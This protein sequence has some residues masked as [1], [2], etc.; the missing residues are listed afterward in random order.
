MVPAKT[1]LPAVFSLGIGSPVMAASSTNDCPLTTWPSTGMRLPGRI[2]TISPG[3]IVGVGH[4]DDLAVSQHAGGLRQE[5]QHVLD[6]ALSATNGQSFEDFRCQHERCNHLLCGAAG[7]SDADVG[8]D[9]DVGRARIDGG[10]VVG[11]EDV[12]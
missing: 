12:V 1:S 10:V 6:S 3:R 4:I 8:G 2:R 11:I 7:V 5:I 9:D